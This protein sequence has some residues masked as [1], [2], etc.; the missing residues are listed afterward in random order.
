MTQGCH[1]RRTVHRQAEIGGHFE[2]YFL[3][4]L[5]GVVPGE[6]L[7]ILRGI[8]LETFEIAEMTVRLEAS[9]EKALDGLNRATTVAGDILD[10][11]PEIWSS[12]S[13]KERAI[14]DDLTGRRG[15]KAVDE[16]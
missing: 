16:S 1:G 12:L 9:L 6:A 10:E 14:I 2:C 13:R 7:D 15:A 4:G 11:H 8:A 3:V 5:F